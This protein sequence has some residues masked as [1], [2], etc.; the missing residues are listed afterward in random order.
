MRALPIV[1]D[2]RGNVRDLLPSLH[3]H[4]VNALAD[5]SLAVAQAGDC[6]AGRVAPRV[7][8]DAAPASARRRFER[9]LANP[10]L[11]PRRVQRELAAGILRHWAGRTIL[12]ILDETPRANDLRAVCVRVAYAGRA[13]PLAG[14]VYRPAAPPRRMPLL[15]RGLLRQVRGCLPG[16]CR[17]VLLADRG[18]AWPTLVDFCA[19]SGWGYVLRLLG[20]TVVRFPDGSEKSARELAPR[21]GS[22]W[23]GAAEAFRKAGWRGAGVVAT[24]ERGMTDPWVPL[25]DERG[26]LRHARVYAKRMWV[27]E[28]FRDDKGGVFGW[29]DSRVDRPSHAARR[30]VLLA[31]AVVLAVS[32]GGAATKA[33]RR[34]AFDPHW[35]RRL[36]IVQ[37]G[38]QWLR[39]AVAHALY[40]RLRLRRLYLYPP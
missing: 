40:D 9:T 16:P 19:E 1:H 14:E 8:T 30:L 31:L 12:L 37:V 21:P 2:W 26:S 28:S 34:R 24:W 10:R 5:L 25:M 6:R 4:Q 33:G 27:E 11:H 29:G 20:Q 39:Y 13:L 22:R 15:V 3:G 7:P 32:R 38:L 18:L 36:S 17:V 35:R 23:V